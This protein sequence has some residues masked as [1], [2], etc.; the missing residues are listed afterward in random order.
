MAVLRGSD[1]ALVAALL[2]ASGA[3]DVTLVQGVV[4]RVWG[5]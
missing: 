5:R 4:D 1:V 3:S 2:A